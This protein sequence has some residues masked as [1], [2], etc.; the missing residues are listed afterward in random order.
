MAWLL[1]VWE[2]LVGNPLKILA[3]FGFGYALCLG[4]RLLF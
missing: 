4:I 1:E 3:L 2:L